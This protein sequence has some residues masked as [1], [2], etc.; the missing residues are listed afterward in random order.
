[1]DDIILRLQ[2]SVFKLDFFVHVSAVKITLSACLHNVFTMSEDNLPD[3]N[4]LTS[5]PYK[6]YTLSG[7]D[8]KLQPFQ[9][10][11]RVLK[12]LSGSVSYR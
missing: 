9:N 12:R 10:I 1:M 8:P 2:H 3:F 4:P 6:G 11:N 7:M 5:S